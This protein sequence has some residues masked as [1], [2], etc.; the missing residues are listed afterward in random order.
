EVMD[1]REGAYPGPNGEFTLHPKFVNQE[2]VDAAERGPLFFRQALEPV[3]NRK[4]NASADR[5]YA[6]AISTGAKGQTL[7]DMAGHDPKLLAS[8]VLSDNGRVRARFMETVADVF[9]EI[10]GHLAD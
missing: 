6:A 1:L 9:E 4:A 8:L 10:K 5:A 3:A 7:A 2:A